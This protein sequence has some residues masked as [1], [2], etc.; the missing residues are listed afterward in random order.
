MKSVVRFFVG[1]SVVLS[2]SVAT[3]AATTYVWSK[4]PLGAT[5]AE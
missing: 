3:A 5:V 4:T 1:A 2:G